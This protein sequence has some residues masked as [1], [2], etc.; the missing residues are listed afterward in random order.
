MQ[1]PFHSSSRE[2]PQNLREDRLIA[3][4]T[5]VNSGDT[6]GETI[7]RNAN[8][9]T[10]DS[11]FSKAQALAIANGRIIAVESN[12]QIEAF[13]GTATNG[14]RKSSLGVVTPRPFCRH[15]GKKLI[16]A[17]PLLGFVKLSSKLSLVAAAGVN[18]AG[19][20]ASGSNAE[21]KAPST[22]C[23]Q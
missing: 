18:G 21:R 23:A 17:P 22:N 3:S 2:F 16:F 9:L 7:I 10:I 14:Q 19:L 8:I 4:I 13:G 6:P 12:N 5:I 15:S 20:P 1:L 11:Q